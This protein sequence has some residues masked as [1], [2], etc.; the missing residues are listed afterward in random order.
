[1]PVIGYES[2]VYNQY[3]NTWFGSV[4]SHGGV[5]VEMGSG[6][7]QVNISNKEVELQSH[8]GPITLTQ[9]PENDYGY[10]VVLPFTQ[11]HVSVGIGGIGSKEGQ[12]TLTI[13]HET[14]NTYNSVTY[15]VSP[16]SLAHSAGTLLHNTGVDIVAGLTTVGTFIW[17]AIKGAGEYIPVFE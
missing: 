10:S 12:P 2:E 4:Q 13:T 15:N 6:D 3:R 7:N 8:F 11:G 1:M 16:K 14:D 17:N 9:G 5:K